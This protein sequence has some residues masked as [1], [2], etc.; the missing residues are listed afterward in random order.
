MSTQRPPSGTTIQKGTSAIYLSKGS[1]FS[2][3]PEQKISTKEWIDHG[4]AILNLAQQHHPEQGV[5][6]DTIF[7]NKF[8]VQTASLQNLKFESSTQNDDQI[9]Q[10]SIRVLVRVILCLGEQRKSLE[11]FGTLTTA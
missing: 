1:S 10:L 2:F 5:G 3:T 4:L 9:E 11:F 7:S 8:Q 6:G